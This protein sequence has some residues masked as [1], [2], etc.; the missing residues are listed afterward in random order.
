MHIGSSLP[1]GTDLVRIGG[2]ESRRKTQKTAF[3][4]L[5]LDKSGRRRVSRRTHSG[6]TVPSRSISRELTQFSSKLFEVEVVLLRCFVNSV[7]FNGAKCF[8]RNAKRDKTV[9]LGP[10]DAAF[11]EVYTLDFFIAFVGE[12]YHHSLSVGGFPRQVA[13]SG[14][15]HQRPFSR[16][17][18]RRRY[19]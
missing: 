19:L 17:D 4:L 5:R 18:S 12:S 16:A 3:F 15:H 7:L 13:V 14:P 6:R 11:L 9:P 10:E 1:H 8:C 2:D